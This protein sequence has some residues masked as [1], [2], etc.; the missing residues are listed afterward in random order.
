MGDKK[1]VDSLRE[2]EIMYTVQRDIVLDI[3]E[4]DGF[5]TVKE[6]YIREKYGST[7]SVMLNAYKWFREKMKEE[8]KKQGDDQ[9]PI[10]LSRSPSIL[11]ISEDSKLLKLSVP[12]DQIILFDNHGWERIL[13]MNY[14]GKDI[15]DEKRNDELFYKKGITTGSDAFMKPYYPMER[16]QIINS[17]IRIFDISNSEYVRGATWK[18]ESDW[19]I[20]E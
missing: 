20:K 7:A 12:R 9:Y 11:T 8:I 6:E 14:V 5:C 1:G 15:E 19:I 16:R 4:K 10:W 13:S 17:W 18:I 2:V 3:I